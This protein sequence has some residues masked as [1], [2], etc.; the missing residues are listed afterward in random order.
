M[1][2]GRS[3]ILIVRS[4]YNRELQRSTH[5]KVLNHLVSIGNFEKAE[6]RAE[7][8]IKIIEDERNSEAE[9]IAYIEKMEQNP[10]TK[11]TQ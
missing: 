3:Q 2:E 10:N 7:E 6:Q 4:L 8:L 9:I 5:E 1:K 11:V